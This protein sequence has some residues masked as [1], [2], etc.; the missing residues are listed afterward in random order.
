[1]HKVL[2][3]NITNLDDAR[4]FAAHMVEWM[5]VSP[6]NDEEL[7]ISL[8][9]GISQWIEG[10]YLAIPISS[11]I[12]LQVLTEKGLCNAAVYTESELYSDPQIGVYSFMELELNPERPEKSLQKVIKQF[13]LAIDAIILNG[14]V[15]TIGLDHFLF[16]KVL[17]STYQL[18]VPVWID[19]DLSLK[20]LK[21]IKDKYPGVGLVVYGKEES[22]L[23]DFSELD[24]FFSAIERD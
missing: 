2:A 23:R 22:G 19:L 17:K 16:K 21:I 14:R 9:K 24:A 12:S 11:S 15:H 4:Y 20:D 10:P 6:P 8:L 7:A 5:V 3:R 13:H 18:P 1:M